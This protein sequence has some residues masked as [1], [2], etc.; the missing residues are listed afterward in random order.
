MSV[1]GNVAVDERAGEISRPEFWLANFPALSITTRL[2]RGVVST[3][4][5]DEPRRAMW[6]ARMLEEGYLQ[7]RADPLAEY[8][9]RLAEAVE[10]CHRLDIPPAFI[11]LFDEAWECF[12][13]LD[14]MLRG[15]L[16]DGYRILPDFW[17]WRIDPGRGE[18]GWR[19]HR[20]KGRRALNPDG[21]PVSLTIWIP[22]TEATP[23][24]GCM[25]L[26]PANRDPVY[27]TESEG[28]W[29]VD[30][31][32]VR[33]LPA[34]PGEFLS[35]NQAVLH[36]GGEASRFAPAPRLSM[37]LEF[38]SGAHAPFNT[39][40]ITPLSNLDFPSRLHLVAKQIL[41]YRHM[42]P[43]AER[44]EALARHLLGV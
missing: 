37:A 33:A 32:K 44:F 4:R 41:Q 22:L 9:P 18:S 8:T 2:A 28:K 30:I 36:W 29:Q 6:Q 40:L 14:P 27:G 10:T 39:P 7:D 34:R 42:Y 15:F 11:F 26:L 13:A 5:A 1:A 38:Q 16:G 43:L 21:S 35:W 23:Q 3:I 19:P 24:N 25:Y 20:D 12:Y 17:T 31:A